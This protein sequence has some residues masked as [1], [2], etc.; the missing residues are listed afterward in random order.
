M[1]NIGGE[2]GRQMA[3]ICGA[4]GFPPAQP[5][6]CCHVFLSGVL[7]VLVQIKTMWF[8]RAGDFEGLFFSHV[9]DLIT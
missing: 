4:A 1:A 7:A 8:W 5:D 6:T 9:E 3:V 2:T